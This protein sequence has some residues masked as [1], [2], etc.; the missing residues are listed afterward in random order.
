MT[1]RWFGGPKQK[2]LW[3]SSSKD[4]AE[5]SENAKYIFTIEKNGFGLVIK[6]VTVEDMNVTYKCYYNFE[7][8]SEMLYSYNAFS[9]MYI[10]Y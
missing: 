7:E 2:P 8:D 10:H 9:G 3:L 5:K 6:N 1:K 4:S